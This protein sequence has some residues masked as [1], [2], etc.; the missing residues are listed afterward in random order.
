MV[1][2]SSTFLEPLEIIDFLA[3]ELQLGE[4]CR[5]ISCQ[6][7]IN[8]AAQARGI[9][10]TPEEIQLEMDRIRY[11]EHLENPSET[12]AWIADQLISLSDWKM[13]IQNRLLTEKLAE[14]MFAAEAAEFFTKHQT[15]F[16]QI[17]LYKITVPYERL[18]QELSYQI[19]EEEI[20]FYEAAHLYNTERNCRLYCGYQGLQYRCDLKPEIAETV[21]NASEGAVIGP[22]KISEEAYDLLLVEAL[23]PARLTADL[24]HHLVAQLFQAW[25]ETELKP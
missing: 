18:C 7:I 14:T 11:Q 2:L 10:I 8:R 21:F 4:V 16:D 1:D 20:S 9:V 13:G 15:D 24:H 12:F 22:L 6:K 25:L 3:Y 17:L 19:E 23:F 5:K